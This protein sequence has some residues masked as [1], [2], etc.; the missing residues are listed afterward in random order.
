MD[1]SSPNKGKTPVQ[2]EG[3]LTP[4]HFRWTYEMESHFLELLLT[5]DIMGNRVVGIFTSL[6]YQNILLEIQGTFGSCIQKNHL[7]NKIG[8]LKQN[9]T[10]FKDLFVV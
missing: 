8:T 9:Y 7:K 2:V 5:E 4:N 1:A 3:N 10:E 6:A